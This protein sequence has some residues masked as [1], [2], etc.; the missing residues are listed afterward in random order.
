MKFTEC[1]A[2]QKKAW[3]NVKYAAQDYI[4]GLENGCHDNPVGS[5]TYNDYLA[6]LK[7][8]E[9]LKEVV[10]HEA[11][12]NIYEDGGVSFGPGAERHMKDIR[13]CGKDF[14]MRLVSKYCKEF[15]AE[16]L[17]SLGIKEA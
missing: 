4:F 9:S 8:L 2:R 3:K 15:Q 5:Q 1:T 6:G 14:I 17:D 11:I 7:D 10:Y 16:A 13:F 12:T